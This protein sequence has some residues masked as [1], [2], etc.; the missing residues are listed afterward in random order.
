[1][2]L[3]ESNGTNGNDRTTGGLGERRA[4]RS[5]SDERLLLRAIKSG[6]KIPPQVKDN[7]VKKLDRFINDESLHARLQIAAIRALASLS[8]AEC[9]SVRTTAYVKRIGQNDAVE[10]RARDV[11]VTLK[12]WLTETHELTAIEAAEA[13]TA[14]T[15]EDRGEE[16][17]N[18]VAFKPPATPENKKHD[19]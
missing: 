10:Q 4:P 19:G 14:A 6:W 13:E 5:Y 8:K 9:D 15:E 18:V 1:M 2:G 11:G 12:E 16:G 17:A 7:A 3:P